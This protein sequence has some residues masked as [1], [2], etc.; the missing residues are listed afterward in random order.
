M[1]EEAM[2]QANSERAEAA[3]MM[4]AMRILTDVVNKMQP[5]CPR[6]SKVLVPDAEPDLAAQGVCCYACWRMVAELQAVATCRK[7]C[8]AECAKCICAKREQHM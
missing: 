4:P 7:C 2:L 1:L 3:T 6:C 5:E 8:F